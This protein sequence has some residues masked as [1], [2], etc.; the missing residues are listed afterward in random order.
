MTWE[1]AY[2]LLKVNV[3]FMLFYA[4]YR[5]FFYQDTFFKLRR[6]ILLLFFALSIVY[7][8][9]DMQDWV[10][11]QEA[12]SHFVNVYSTILPE[13]V[14]EPGKAPAVIQYAWLVQ[15]FVFVYWGVVA[16]LIGRFLFQMGSIFY[17]AKRSKRTQVN[18]VQVYVMPES[19]GPFSFFRMIFIHPESHAADE[20]SEILAHEQAHASQWH[21]I[22]VIVY[23]LMNIICWFN[24]FV[25]LLKREV[26]YNL[27]Y[28]AD[29]RVMTAGFDS[30]RYQYHLVG[31]AHHSSTSVLSNNFN[32]PYLKSRI[33]MMNKKRSC[34]ILRV[35]YLLFLPLVVIMLL[36]SNVDA[37]ARLVARETKNEV[38]MVVEQM[39]EFPGGDIALLN[40]IRQQVKYPAES[41]EKN[42]QGRVICQ[43][44]VDKIGNIRDI[45]VLRGI[46]P[47][48]D[49]EAMRVLKAMPRWKPGMQK[50]VPVDVRYTVPIR[51]SL[52]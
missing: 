25:W 10:R 44:V 20:I 33:L 37:V 45:E 34:G 40:F 27:E 5:L 13:I 30:K 9:L 16:L 29:N 49:Q 22:D 26:R 39:P 17:I 12:I 43:F 1:F 3:A 46:S 4:F 23:E 24:P 21:S 41:M 15:T 52:Q 11:D 31:L 32:M 51:F 8:L 48:L 28:L 2:Y 19:A 18:G 36:L 7:P 35:K 38:F 50:G 42:E 6:F 14:I 47:L